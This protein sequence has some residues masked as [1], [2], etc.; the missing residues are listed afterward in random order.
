MNDNPAAR[1]AYGEPLPG[2]DGFDEA[3]AQGNFEFARTRFIRSI[4]SDAVARFGER[5]NAQRRRLRAEIDHLRVL[6]R[7]KHAGA[8]EAARSYGS[9]LPH[10]VGKTWIRPPGQAENGGV[11]LGS[12]RLCKIAARRDELVTIEQT[13]HDRL[14]M[15][16][17]ALIEEL[18]SPRALQVALL[19]DPLLNSAYQKLKEL[20]E[21]FGAV[22]GDDVLADL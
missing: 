12:Q 1:G 10:R 3:L 22:R 9:V 20:R 14:D 7:A 21:E 15:R 19:R 4:T 11:F 8:V 18:K 6:L 17:A 16:E 13:L 5:T 2:H